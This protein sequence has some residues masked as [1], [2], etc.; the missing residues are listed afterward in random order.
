MERTSYAHNLTP[1]QAA[2]ATLN[3]VNASSN[4]DEELV[5]YWLQTDAAGSQFTA[6]LLPTFPHSTPSEDD[7]LL[8]S[9]ERGALPASLLQ[10]VAKLSDQRPELNCFIISLTKRELVN[11]LHSSTQLFQQLHERRWWQQGGFAVILRAGL[12]RMGAPLSKIQDVMLAGLLHTQT[13]WVLD[14][15]SESSLSINAQDV[16]P[17]SYQQFITD[18]EKLT[19]LSHFIPERNRYRESY[20][21]S[22]LL[23]L[24]Q[25]ELKSSAKFSD[26]VR[27][28]L[29][30]FAE[31]FAAQGVMEKLMLKQP[32]IYFAIMKMRKKRSA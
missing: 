19:R 4:V 27:H 12:A 10:D 15:A 11:G 2:P 30:Y 3:R 31:N 6:S 20:L 5:C 21:R 7:F 29:T 1:Q 25:Q 22:G 9:A 32:D 28:A 13:S 17:F 16:Q 14:Y 8:F 24:V 26:N 23:Q 18:Y